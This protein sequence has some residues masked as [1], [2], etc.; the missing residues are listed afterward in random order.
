MA[1]LRWTNERPWRPGLYLWYD[2]QTKRVAIGH[3]TPMNELSPRL[4]WNGGIPDPGCEY[5]RFMGP[6]PE[7]QEPTP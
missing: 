6:I 5:C 2:C 1:D 7:P 3:M 4:L